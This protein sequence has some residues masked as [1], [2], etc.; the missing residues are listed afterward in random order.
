MRWYD[1]GISPIPKFHIIEIHVPEW[2][3]LKGEGLGR[4]CI[5]QI[6]FTNTKY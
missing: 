5:Y 4:Y 3:N 6:I 2:V 1:L